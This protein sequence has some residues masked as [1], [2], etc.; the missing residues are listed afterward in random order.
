[1]GRGGREPVRESVLPGTEILAR[2]RLTPGDLAQTGRIARAIRAE[3]WYGSLDGARLQAHLGA[4]KVL[5]DERPWRAPALLY[6]GLGRERAAAVCVESAP[7]IIAGCATD[8]AAIRHVL[9]Q[10]P[11]EGVTRLLELADVLGPILWLS[12]MGAL[13]EIAAAVAA[14]TATAEHAATVSSDEL[15]ADGAREAER[16]LRDWP[17][18]GVDLDA[19]AD[20]VRSYAWSPGTVPAWDEQPRMELVMVHDANPSTIPWPTQ[21][22]ALVGQRWSS[23]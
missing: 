20:L 3:L 6:L 1:M 4:T 13:R 15:A 21:P 9:G 12:P 11:I 18:V 8:L 23:P 14:L 5:A 19:A 22:P 17:R 2:A 16:R 10:S 7:A